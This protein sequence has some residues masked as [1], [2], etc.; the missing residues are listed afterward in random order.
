M[1]EEVFAV[2]MLKPKGRVTAYGA[3]AT[4]LGEARLMR[5]FAWA[6]NQSFSA[7]SKVLSH[8]YVSKLGMLSGELH[9]PREHSMVDEHREDGIQVKDGQVVELDKCFWDPMTEL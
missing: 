7:K 9:F 6:L 2:V 8:R 1:N 3:I 4:Y 5:W